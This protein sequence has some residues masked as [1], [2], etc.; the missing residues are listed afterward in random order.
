MVRALDGYYE[1]AIGKRAVYVRVHGLA[2]M[3]NCLCVRDFIEKMLR[4]GHSF[5]VVDLA[6]C[7]GMDSTFMGVLA[8]AATCAKDDPRP[9]VAVVNASEHLAG[10][11][12]SVGLSELLFVDPKPFEDA[13]IAFVPLGGN[14]SEEER[15]ACIHDAHE[16]LLEAS[17]ENEK[18]FGPFLTTLEA[19]M[20]AKGLL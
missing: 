6:D 2:S 11:L 15:L 20:K 9:G 5:L 7:T 8:G 4:S 13:R 18:L 1:V 14:G 12:E 19:E 17:E 16:R 3:N 10:L